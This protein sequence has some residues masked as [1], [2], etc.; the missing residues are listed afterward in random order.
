MRRALLAVSLGAMM[1]T[2]TACDSAAPRTE[3]A[4]AP[5][6]ETP[7]EAPTSPPPDYTADTRKVCGGV[8]QAVGTKLPASFGTQIGKMIA[9]KEAKDPADADK[10]EQAAVKLLKSAADDIQ[11]RTAAAQ[12]PDLRTAGAASAAKLTRSATDSAFFDEIKST[13][14]LDRIIEARMGEWLGPITGYCA[15]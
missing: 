9:Y 11:R 5:I 7:S 10:Y 1:L 4:P 6:V 2:G 8:Q 13:K 15:T 3:A 14:D 12:D